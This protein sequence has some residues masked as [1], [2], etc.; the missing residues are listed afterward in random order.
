ME[1]TQAYKTI[2]DAKQK[3]VKNLSCGLSI[4]LGLLCIL[5]IPLAI[6]EFWFFFFFNLFGFVVEILG[7]IDRSRNICYL[8]LVTQMLLM[9]IV[10]ITIIF[11]AYLYA[12]FFQVN[13]WVVGST[14]DFNHTVPAVFGVTLS[15]GIMGFI[16]LNI[17][18]VMKLL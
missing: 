10:P 2:E 14:S 6:S 9:I 4:I 3:T 13:E 17:Y 8:L 1:S 12:G 7:F 11:D 18:Q 5:S 16:A 15:V